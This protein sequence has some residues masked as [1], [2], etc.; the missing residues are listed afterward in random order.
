MNIGKQ[1]RFSEPFRSALIIM[2]L[3]WLGMN[4][5]IAA[6]ELAVPRQ[7]PA[8]LQEEPATS[9][10]TAMEQIPAALQESTPDEAVVSEQIPA[11][12]QDTTTSEQS[13]SEQIPAALQDISTGESYAAIGDSA[14][15]I[16]ELD[17]APAASET[18]T[19]PAE[20]PRT[21]AS[22]RT[23]A[24]N[25]TP[26]ATQV[27]AADQAPAANQAPAEDSVPATNVNQE[28]MTRPDFVDP[29][30]TRK[31]IHVAAI[32]NENF[33]FGLF[34]GMFSTEDFGTSP[35]YGLKLAYHINEAVFFEV[36][37]GITKTQRTSAEDILNVDFLSDEERELSYYNFSFG[38]N[39]LP[40]ETYFSD[41]WAFHSAI[42]VIGGAGF[43]EFAGDSFFTLN[44][45]VGYRF[46]ATDWLA[47]HLDV[48]DHLFEMD[49]LGEKKTTQNIEFSTGVS[50]FF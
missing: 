50:F 46:L 17:S 48:K 5:A 39:A 32:D 18:T 9:E 24:G 11:A 33:E 34:L 25:V 26:A 21:P 1:R 49:L 14:T 3:I 2:G 31:E 7:G 44:F 43:T 42:Y 23:G 13:G 40:S 4:P 12:L 28:I 16:P 45:G 15:E 47:L 6:D 41:K 8:V 30:V 37:T 22:T 10:A 20:A 27:P 36:A 29:K 38:F 19:S 35:V